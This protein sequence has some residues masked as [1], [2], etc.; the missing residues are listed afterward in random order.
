MT[1]RDKAC[2]TGIGETA[3]MRGSTKTAFELQLAASL[4]AIADAG[5]DPKEIDGV[6]P[7]GIVSGT[8]DDFIDNF[9]LPDLRFSALVPH[10]GASPV[11]ALQAAAAAVAVGACNHVLIAFGGPSPTMRF[12]PPLPPNCLTCWSRWTSRRACVHWGAG[13]AI[14][15]QFWALL[16]RA[17]LKRER[18]AST[19]CSRRG[20]IDRPA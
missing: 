4:S 14:A 5:L 9:G 11:M 15:N 1:L 17:A 13:A 20:P 12:T 6:I 10:G 16:C 7:I 2:V 3:Y 8:A 19:W 18:A